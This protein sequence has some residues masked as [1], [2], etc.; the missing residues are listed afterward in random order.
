[1]IIDSTVLSELV[2]I[3]S[4]PIIH[5]PYIVLMLPVEETGPI[6]QF[7]TLSPN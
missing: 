3:H 7:H 1:M 4:V 2:S 6:K 5:R